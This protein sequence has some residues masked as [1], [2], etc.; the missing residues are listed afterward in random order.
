MAGQGCLK[1]GDIKATYGTGCFINLN[2]GQQVINSQHGLLTMVAW[3]RDSMATYGLDGGVF[4]AGA[5]IS[6]LRDGI[7]LLS[8]QEDID[9]LC[10]DVTD[11]GG[12]LWLPAQAGLG[13]PYWDRQSRGAWLGLELATSKAQLVRAV[14]EGI[15]GRVAQIV[16][17]MESDSGMTIHHLQVDGG[18]AQCRTL[19]QIQANL[20]GRPVDVLTD[21]QATASG[22][23]GLAARAL[24]LWDSDNIILARIQVGQTYE[25]AL[26]SEARENWLRRFDRALQHLKSWH[27]HD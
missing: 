10:A 14:L 19:M 17:A 15:A 13:A 21:V 11:S 20:L 1:S 24:G 26:T 5:S 18:L 9:G 3:Q 2:T 4:T 22:A 25:P 27:S 6:W 12:V 23:C 16:Q 8:A 7:G